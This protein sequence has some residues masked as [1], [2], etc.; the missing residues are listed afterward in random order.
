MSKKAVIVFILYFLFVI[1]IVPGVQAVVELRGDSKDDENIS[2]IK[3]LEQLQPFHFFVDTFITPVERNRKIVELLETLALK[4]DLAA[5][6]VQQAAA[7]AAAAQSDADTTA[8]ETAEVDLSDVYYETG[9]EEKISDA[10]FAAKDLFNRVTTINRHVKMKESKKD[11]IFLENMEYSL[12]ALA[13]SAL[14]GSDPSVI[15]G[16]L[17]SIQSTVDSL[18]QLK[19]YQIKGAGEYPHTLLNTLLFETIGANAYIRGY[20]D[21]MKDKSIFANSIRP[22]MQ[23]TQYVLIH[24]VGSKGVEGDHGWLFFKPGFDYLVN[25]YI[26]DRRSKLVDANDGTNK[27]FTDDPISTIKDFQQQLNSQGIDLLMVVVPG[28]PSVY[29]ELISD[30]YTPED[31]CRVSHSVELIDSM[32]QAG[33]DVVDLFGPFA[34]ARTHDAEAGDSLYLRTDTHWRYRGLSLAAE[35]VA[36]RVK[37][38][39]WYHDGSKEYIMEKVVVDREGDVG[40]M[41]QFPAFKVHDLNLRFPLEKTPCYKIFEVRRDEEGTIVSKRP[42]RDD[43]SRRSQIMLLGDSFSR[44]YQTDLP[45][46]AGWISHLARHLKQPLYTIVN[47]GG[48]S[49][50]VRETLANKVEEK[51]RE[52]KRSPLAGKK[53]VIWEFIERDFRFGAEGW[54]RIEL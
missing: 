28:K 15:T 46:S 42:Y 7:Q 27:A 5:A 22:W 10:K 14:D 34:E 20:E 32:R 25:P 21:E 33:I 51:E 53:L 26:Y 16:G 13:D 31:A 40:V 50:L 8:S 39:D 23:F 37:G 4:L 1:S 41:T 52:G 19:R 12:N 17:N 38:Y 36:K 24:D 44:I 45:N 11:Y 49:T 18:S 2:M 47:D 29:P 35:E 30:A 54:K 6:S 9:T 48:A 3:K 43:Y